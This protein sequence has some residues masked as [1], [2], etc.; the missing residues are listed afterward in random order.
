MSHFLNYSKYYNLLYLDKDY[1][2]EVDY[3]DS[4]IK[5]FHP[6]TTRIL[7]VGCGTGRHAKLLADKGYKIHGIDLSEQMLEIALQSDKTNTSFSSGDIR[8]F[9]L[10]QKFDTIT[11][12]F[13]VMS[14]QTTNEDVV[15]SFNTIHKHLEDDGIFIFDCWY[16]PAVLLD[17]P[18]LRVKE[19]EDANLKVI[20]IT[21]PT[22]DFNKSIVEVNF[23]VNVFDKALRTMQTIQEQHKMRYFFQNELYFFTERCGFSIVDCHAWLTLKTPD[24]NSW[25]ITTVCKKEK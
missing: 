18:G 8:N 21:R 4:L 16:G 1:Q 11:S 7:D 24:K 13:H 23:E 20:R 22:V 25:Y 6:K 19:M 17:L 15:N 9:D 14:Y 2:S 10:K 3:I 5:R 12:L